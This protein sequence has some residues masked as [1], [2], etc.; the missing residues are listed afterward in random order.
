MK[1]TK[2]YIFNSLCRGSLYGI[3]TYIRELQSTLDKAKIEYGII[4]IYGTGKFVTTSDEAGHITINIPKA[5]YL[6]KNGS[7]YYAR[8]ISFLLREFIQ[9]EKDV[10]LIFHLNFMG[11]PNLVAAL[12]KEFPKSKIVLVAHYTNWSFNLKG[13]EGQLGR[14][15]RKPAKYRSEQEQNLCKAFKADLKMIRKVDRFICVAQHT[16][17]TYQKYGTIDTDKCV[18]INNALTDSFHHLEDQE[19]NAIREKYYISSEEQV[20][21]YAG[22]LDPDKGVGALIQAFGILKKNYPWLHLYLLGEGDYNH[23]LRIAEGNWSQI[24]FTGKLDKEKVQDFYDIANIGV[25]CSLHEAFGLTA[26]EM[27]MNQLPIVVSDAGGLDEIVE[28]EISGLKVHVEKS[29]DKRS[30]S[31]QSLA[32]QISRLLDD[33]S[34]SRRIA[35]GARKRFLENYEI[36]DYSTK[37]VELYQTI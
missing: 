15:L 36:T 11:E 31:P 24:T 37:M 19:K 29:E 18:V 4:Y 16:L 26:V 7:K 25:V 20:L 8:N 3:G 21:L 14:I 28:D 33:M 27:M 23:W 5:Q 1:R 9:E 10:D 30:I 35:E 13:D 17:R 12:K 22:R 32:S 34:L 2:V 6:N